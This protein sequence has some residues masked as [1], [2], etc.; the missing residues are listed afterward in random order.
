MICNEFKDKKVPK[1]PG[2][3]D[4]NDE[5]FENKL[6][7]RGEEQIRGRKYSLED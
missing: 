6:H 7:Q 1:D 3:Y 4:Y 2:E 5:E